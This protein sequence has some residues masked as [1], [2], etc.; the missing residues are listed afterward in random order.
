M[1]RWERGLWRTSKVGLPRVG[2][3]RVRVEIGRVVFLGAGTWFTACGLAV[4]VVAVRV[5]VLG[6]DEPG[7]PPGGLPTLM[8]ALGIGAVIFL[9]GLRSDQR[10]FDTAREIEDVQQQ[11]N[12]H[13]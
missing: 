7:L 8:G 1:P 11:A 3:P 5:V 4:L 13:P 2:P 10:R 6:V 12:L 9:V